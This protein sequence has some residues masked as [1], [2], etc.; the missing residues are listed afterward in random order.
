MAE[1]RQI[2]ARAKPLRLRPPARGG[3]E[4]ALLHFEGA[5]PPALL[6]HATGF[7]KG[8]LALL[9]A[10]LTPRYRVFVMDARGHG[11]STAPPPQNAR[12]YHWDEFAQDAAA[13]AAHL[14]AEYGG[15]E[16]RLALALGH[17]FGGT[18]LLRAAHLRPDLFGALVLADPVAPP[19]G[20]HGASGNALAEGA[21]RRRAQFASREEARARWAAKPFFQNCLPEALDLYAL[22]GLRESAGGGVELKCAPETEAAVFE[23]STGLAVEQWVGEVQAPVLWLWAARQSFPREYPAALAAKIPRGQFAEMAAGHLAPLETPQNILREVQKF[24]AL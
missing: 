8:T 11:D 16:G 4:I 22:D 10:E 19:P 3:M 12:A 6:H 2:L 7:C 15:A 24:A 20:L 9:A 5:G 14:A 17:S 21:R 23:N 18:A 13:V 1:A